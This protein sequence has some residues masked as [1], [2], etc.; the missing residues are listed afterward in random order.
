M[1]GS[2]TPLP[3][4][5]V[6]RNLPEHARNRIHTDAGAREAGFPRALVAGVT[7]YAYLTHPVAEAWGL[8]WVSSGGGE[9]RFRRP[10]FDGDLVRCDIEPTYEGVAVAAITDEPEQHVLCFGPSL[11]PRP[12]RP[13]G[14]ASRSR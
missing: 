4:S 5:I 11:E 1:N 12:W 8:G 6:A 14:P 7:T 3:W 2:S 9:V 13:S 10:V